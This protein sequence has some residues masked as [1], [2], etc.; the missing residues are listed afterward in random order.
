L[1][2]LSATRLFITSHVVEGNLP[3]KKLLEMLSTC[4]GLRVEDCSSRKP[5]LSWLKLTSRIVMLLEYTSSCGKP[6]DSMLLDKF[7][8][9]RP[10][11]LP[12]DGE[13]CP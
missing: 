8:R 9:R 6:P 13:M 1:L 4:R 10:V 5:P 2:A 11:R 3:A 7:N 12:R